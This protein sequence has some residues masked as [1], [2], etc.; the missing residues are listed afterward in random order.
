MEVTGNTSLPLDGGSM[1]RGS[2]ASQL[3]QQRA[4]V[5]PLGS[6]I[7]QALG[8]SR[9]KGR[10]GQGAGVLPEWGTGAR[11]ERGGQRG[12]G[13][14]AALRCPLV[15]KTDGHAAGLNVSASKFF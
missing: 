9:P 15:L 13:T 7:G 11:G 6:C 4:V 10:H 8:V 1:R 5:D 12:K 3:Q 2:A 14:A